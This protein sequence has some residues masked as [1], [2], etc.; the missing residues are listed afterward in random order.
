MPIKI[1]A[2]IIPTNLIRVM[3]A[4][5][6]DYAILDTAYSSSS[7]NILIKSPFLFNC[8]DKTAVEVVRQ[9]FIFN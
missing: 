6:V 2:E 5:G 7:E 4:E 9:K 3:P 8:F 1:R